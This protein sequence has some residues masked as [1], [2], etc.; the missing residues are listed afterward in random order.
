MAAL[1]LQSGQKDRAGEAARRE[2]ALPI[3]ELSKN[4]STRDGHVLMQFPDSQSSAKPASTT[5]EHPTARPAM[6][7]FA[8]PVVP[9]PPELPASAVLQRIGMIV[10]GTDQLVRLDIRQN[11][12]SVKV[13]VHSDDSALA[14][15]LR[16]TLPELINR[17]EDRGLQARVTSFGSASPQTTRSESGGSSGQDQSAWS[18]DTDRHQQRRE[19]NP[20][21]VWREA[22]WKLEE[23]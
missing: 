12:G 11:M 23:D 22:T 17:L 5:I 8:E 3:P 21:R 13:A 19:R 18:R 10:R 7:H 6:T 20:R 1:N 15:Q 2:E 16:E 9:M 14:S 4:D